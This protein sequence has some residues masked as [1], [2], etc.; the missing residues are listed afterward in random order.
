MQI[1]MKMQLGM[2]MQGSNSLYFS[3]SWVLIISSPPP[4]L[5]QY[6]LFFHYQL[7][8]WL[9]LNMILELSQTFHGI[10]SE[11][12]HLSSIQPSLLTSWQNIQLGYRFGTGH[13]RGEY[14]STESYWSRPR[15]WT[16]NGVIWGQWGINVFPLS[17]G[18]N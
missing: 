2:K 14:D 15:F 11:T 16:L 17:L 9:S 1:G 7:P 4:F 5:L 10:H 13:G 18:V 8:K 12:V 3:F 6:Y